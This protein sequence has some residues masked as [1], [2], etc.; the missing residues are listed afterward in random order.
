MILNFL[1]IVW[2]TLIDKIQID[3]ILIDFFF[4]FLNN[5]FKYE[6]FY[7]LMHIL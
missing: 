3:K 1:E 4:L 7:N 5:L 6:H 2:E